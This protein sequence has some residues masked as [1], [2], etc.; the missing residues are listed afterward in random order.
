MCLRA[1]ARACSPPAA[2]V[3][4]WRCAQEAPPK[5]RDK[6][7]FKENHAQLKEGAQVPSCDSSA[8]IQDI[9][10]RLN[11]LQDFLKAAKVPR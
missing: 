8:D 9:D 11:A 6:E 10:R 7:A 5:A 1:A 3:R 4:A 2:E